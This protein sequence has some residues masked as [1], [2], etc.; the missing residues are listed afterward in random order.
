M[1]VLGAVALVMVLGLA[2]CATS[3]SAERN[4][5]ELRISQLEREVKAKD[6]QMA[7]LQNEVNSKEAA[8]KEAE[9]KAK[10][11]DELVK[12]QQG[13]PRTGIIRVNQSVE[14]IQQLLKKVGFYDGKVDGKLGPKTKEAIVEFQKSNDLKPDGIV[15]LA[16][17]AKLSEYK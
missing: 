3:Q 14:E 16:T 10:K 5:L 4:Y 15:G 6:A 17:W 13:R 7:T 2:G 8:L 9:E 1:R 12:A 11:W